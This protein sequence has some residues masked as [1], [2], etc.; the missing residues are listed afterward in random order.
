M[1]TLIPKFD[2]NNSLGLVTNPISANRPENLKLSEFV[3]VLDF[4]ADNTGVADSTTAIQNAINTL[5]VGTLYFPR[6]TYKISSTINVGTDGTATEIQLVGESSYGPLAG[7]G[8]ATVITAPT[9]ASGLPMFVVGMPSTNAQNIA[10]VGMKFI[11]SG[12][13]ENTCIKL[14]NYIDA[15]SMPGSPSGCNVNIKGCG[16]FNSS[17]GIL[18]VSFLSQITECEFR[19]LSS[20]IVLWPYSQDVRIDNNHFY[21][22]TSSSINFGIFSQTNFQSGNNIITRNQFESQAAN[23]IDI[24]V[25]TLISSVIAYN[26]FGP[27]PVTNTANIYVSSGGAGTTPYDIQNLMIIGNSFQG[28]PSQG[29]IYFQ[30]AQDNVLPNYVNSQIVGNTGNQITLVSYENINGNLGEQFSSIVTSNLSSGGVKY[31]TN[32]LAPKFN[33]K[34]LLSN[35]NFVSPGASSYTNNVTSFPTTLTNPANWNITATGT[36]SSVQWNVDGPLTG[37]AVNA[38]GSAYRFSVSVN[39]GTGYAVAY[40][41]VTVQANQTYTF[42]ALANPASTNFFI[43][44]CK[45]DGTVLSQ[46]GINNGATFTPGNLLALATSCNSGSNTTLQVRIINGTSSLSY[47][48]YAAMYD[49][50]W[51]TNGIG[52]N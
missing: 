38:S 46:G 32:S 19:N 22:T 24:N 39:A 33:N 29:N 28:L 34:N 1:T 8:Y 27:S 11:N 42:V 43:Q 48:Y 9:L 20:G 44:I 12:Q 26:V 50:L 47:F 7:Y 37:L 41:N 35:G 14:S 30:V 45:T 18:G 16:F 36:V 21:G 3:S 25:N 2:F 6:G 52:F 15:A 23:S 40:Q 10:F 49:G 51:N 13:S 5:R 4:G 17:Y 31:S